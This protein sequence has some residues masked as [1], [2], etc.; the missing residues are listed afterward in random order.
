MSGF[1]PVRSPCRAAAAAVAA[2]L[3]TLVAMPACAQREDE[4]LWLQVNANVPLSETTRLTVE[5]IARFGDRDGGLFQTEF[6][7]L[8]SHRVGR[9]FEVGIGYR[10][11]GA[12]GGNRAADEDRLRQQVVGNFGRLTVRLR[13]DERFHPDGPEIGF[14]LRPQLRYAVPVGAHGAALF[15]SHESFYL[16][17]ATRWG[18]R[19]GYERMRNLIGATLPIA[20][21]LSADIGYL[22]QFRP[23]R[24]GVRAQMDH[25][26]AM[27]LT[28][29]LG[30]DSAGR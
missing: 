26:L 17:N 15:V 29:R 16:P 28:I 13:L 19:Q 21:G 22:N 30:R 24:R 23:A 12:H 4:Q 7:G 27:Q 5:Q 10:R 3:G 25:A 18:Q 11:V 2:A 6:G 1:P 20:R 8:V 9:R 14:R